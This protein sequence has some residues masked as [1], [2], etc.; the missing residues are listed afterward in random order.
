VAAEDGPVDAGETTAQPPHVDAV[1]SDDAVSGDG[2]GPS[3]DGAEPP[4]ETTA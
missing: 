4:P 1:Q 2:A 3:D